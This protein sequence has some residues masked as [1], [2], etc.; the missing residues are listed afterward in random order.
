VVLV[1]A[2]FHDFNQEEEEEEE[3]KEE[4]GQ[5]LNAAVPQFMATQICSGLGF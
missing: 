4:G 1:N 5:H 2:H 3:E